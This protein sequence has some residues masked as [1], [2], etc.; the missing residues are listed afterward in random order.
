MGSNH[1]EVE[2]TGAFEHSDSKP[3][4]TA[5]ESFQI[6]FGGKQVVVE[7]DQTPLVM[8]VIRRSYQTEPFSPY[9]T[10]NS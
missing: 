2:A 1:Q 6:V 5:D 4:Y 9:Q 7:P 10:I 8:T 3:D